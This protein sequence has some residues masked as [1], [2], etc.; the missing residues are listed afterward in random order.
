M[1]IRDSYYINK[2][3]TKV[4]NLFKNTDIKITSK[5][6]KIIEGLNNTHKNDVHPTTNEIHNN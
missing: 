4:R 6:I 1:C 2:R 3:M 5:L